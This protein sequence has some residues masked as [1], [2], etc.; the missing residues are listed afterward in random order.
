MLNEAELIV[1]CEPAA[2]AVLMHHQFIAPPV[3]EVNFFR[4]TMS[5]LKGLPL[6]TLFGSTERFERSPL[7]SVAT[8]D[9]LS[10][11]RKGVLSVTLTDGLKMRV[12]RLR[13]VALPLEMIKL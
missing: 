5:V 13:V 4:S 6:T 1:V 7:Q 3:I 12:K 10:K 9:E 2:I 11:D 8:T